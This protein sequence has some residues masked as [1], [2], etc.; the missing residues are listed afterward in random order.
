MSFEVHIFERSLTDQ[1]LFLTDLPFVA[2]RNRMI[3]PSVDQAA[4]ILSF[5]FTS[6]FALYRMVLFLTVRSSS[7]PMWVPF[8][9]LRFFKN[10]SLVRYEVHFTMMGLSFGA[11]LPVVLCAPAAAGAPTR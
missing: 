6:S 9:F 10:L 1:I 4:S 11:L 2:F 8:S 7:M 3:L 5:F